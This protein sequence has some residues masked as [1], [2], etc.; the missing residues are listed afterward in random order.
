[1]M[2]FYTTCTWAMQ[3]HTPVYSKQADLG[4]QLRSVKRRYIYLYFRLYF[5]LNII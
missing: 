4:R 5:T 3:K 2:Q 1:M